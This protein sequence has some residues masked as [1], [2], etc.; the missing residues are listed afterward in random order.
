MRFLQRGIED[1]N[2]KE[3]KGCYD[4]SKPW[5]RAK[6]LYNEDLSEQRLAINQK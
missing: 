2:E 4:C 5:I 6:W 3:E 1:I